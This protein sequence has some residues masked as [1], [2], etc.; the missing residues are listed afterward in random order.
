MMRLVLKSFLSENKEVLGREQ[1]VFDIDSTEKLYCSIQNQTNYIRWFI[2]GDSQ[3]VNS[4][5]GK[6]IKA[7]EN[8]ELSIEKVQLSDGGTYEC[9]RLQYVQY[10]T[11]YVN[12]RTTG[13]SPHR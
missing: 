13:F 11:I 5:T 4:T 6:R 3:E 7:T 9:Q 1:L 8:G 12:G 10:Y 2:N